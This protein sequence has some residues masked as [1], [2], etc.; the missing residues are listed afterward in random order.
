MDCNIENDNKL[1]FALRFN[2][3]VYWMV[4]I[5]ESGRDLLGKGWLG[6]KILRRWWYIEGSFLN[7]DVD[8]D[9]GGDF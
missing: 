6:V 5:G 3:L 4:D 1:G 8:R 9:F 7:G 2:D